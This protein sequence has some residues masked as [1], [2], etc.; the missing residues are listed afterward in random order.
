VRHSRVASSFSVFATVVLT[1]AA[2]LW[3]GCGKKG[4][5]LPP[6][7]KIP[8]A[9]PGFTA[10]RH[11]ATVDLQFTVP[12]ANTDGT[13]PA[14]IERVDVYGMTGPRTVNA[15]ELLRRGR[16]IQS[17]A[18]KKPRNPNDTIDLDETDDELD[19]LEGSGHDQGSI[20]HVEDA[21]GSE[22]ARPE[23]E[24][25]SGPALGATADFVRP[26]VAPSIFNVATRNYVTVGISTGGRKGTPSRLV[27]VSLAPL[28]PSPSVPV[29]TYD[30]KAITVKWTPPPVGEIQSAASKDLLPAT[31]IGLPAPT[32]SYN[33]Y[34]VPPG[35][36]ERPAEERL[37]KAPVTEPQYVDSSVQWGM[38]R[39]YVVRVVEAV[40]DLRLE[41]DPSPTACKKL[42]D[43][44][45]PAAPKGL[46]A[47]ASEN[48]IS[49]IWQP[50]SEADLAGYVVF[51]G[52]PPGEPTQQLTKTPIQGTT[53]DD[54]GQPG[55]A[56]VYV[57]KALDKS[58][59]M[60]PAS[61]TAEETIR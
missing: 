46:T 41:S 56:Y 6:L 43:T 45:P 61:N 51:R 23:T 18:V 57:V 40:G 36:G 3:L 34:T 24:R 27:S 38:E 22:I 16:L 5:P 20:V 60:S 8:V 31:P 7:V 33:V 58:G 10:E 29:I 2:T 32:F 14:N 59:N 48:T 47:V 19:P 1:L 25:R 30:E 49:L 50:N 12:A 9:P 55:V 44:F 53:Y 4:P 37:T 28:P 17:V 26:L 11:G 15:A 35:P 13:R 42:L 39:C 52:T 21:L 54:A